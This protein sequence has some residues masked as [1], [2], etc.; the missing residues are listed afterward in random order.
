M[1]E[2][3]QGKCDKTKAKLESSGKPSRHSSFMPIHAQPPN[4]GG[5]SWILR[6]QIIAYSSFKTLSRKSWC[7]CATKQ[8]VPTIGEHV[9]RLPR[10]GWHNKLHILSFDRVAAHQNLFARAVSV[11][12]DQFERVTAVHMPD[13]FAGK[14][15]KTRNAERFF[16]VQTNH[17]SAARC[18]VGLLE[19]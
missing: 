13:F 3:G 11:K 14:A 10:I 6:D 5:S 1:L 2:F 8:R 12:Q 19:F 15:V 4:I 17:G 16:A 18:A 7:H 9:P